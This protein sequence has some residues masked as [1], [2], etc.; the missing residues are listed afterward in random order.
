MWMAGLKKFHQ[1]PDKLMINLIEKKIDQYFSNFFYTEPDFL[2]K[3]ETGDILLI[4][5]DNISSLF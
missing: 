2:K 4:Q 5:T 3:V 1:I